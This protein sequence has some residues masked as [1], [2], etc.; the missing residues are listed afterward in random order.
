MIKAADGTAS[1]V[2]QDEISNIAMISEAM[3]RMRLMIGRRIIGRMAL[4]ARAPE[5][6]LSHLDV[7][8]AFRR[9]SQEGEVTV[10]AV[11]EVMRVDHSRA[12]RLV[13]DLVDRGLLVRSASQA[14]ARR[15]VVELTDQG[16]SLANAA[17]E[18]K[19]KL[20]AT[21]VADWPAQDV[22]QFSTLFLRFVE[23]FEN[24]ARIPDS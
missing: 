3:A 19:R 18:V 11:A 4:S 9:A 23:G 12:S 21:I 10:G 24:A 5:L 7:V 15:T 6:D 22:E 17:H 16:H 2:A 1:A 13:S 8:S 20:I 14:D